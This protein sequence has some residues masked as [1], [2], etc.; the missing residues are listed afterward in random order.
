VASQPASHQIN[1]FGRTRP[2]CHVKD[3]RNIGPDDIP[4]STCARGSSGQQSCGLNGSDAHDHDV[5][6]DAIGSTSKC[7]TE[8][9]GSKITTVGS[10]FGDVVG[11]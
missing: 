6:G 11:D 7:N 8:I 4:A 3:E 10:K 1:V 2:I 9:A 5:T